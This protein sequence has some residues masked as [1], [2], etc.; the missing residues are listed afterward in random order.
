[1]LAAAERT[2]DI[3]VQQTLL[4]R[5][6][7]HA[8]SDD[9]G[10]MIA[11]EHVLGSRLLEPLEWERVYMPQIPNERLDSISDEVRELHPLLDLLLRKLPRVKDVEYHHGPAEMGAD[12]IVEREDEA[13]RK[14]SMTLRH[15]GRSN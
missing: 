15:Q 6:S 5:R 1:M 12:F 8:R 14:L 10:V 11:N 7:R 4:S 9:L 3:N 13:F 2:A